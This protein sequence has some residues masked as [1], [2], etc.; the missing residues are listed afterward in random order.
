MTFTV[1][2]AVAAIGILYTVIPGDDGMMLR[3]PVTAVSGAE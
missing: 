1:M 2:R 3:K